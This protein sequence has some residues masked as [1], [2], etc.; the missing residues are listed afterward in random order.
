MVIL[1]VDRAQS[2]G[3]VKKHLQELLAVYGKCSKI[4]MFH[5]LFT[6]K[7]VFIRPGIH[8]MPVRIANREYPDQT[9]SI[10]AV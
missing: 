10:E 3:V 6:N 2:S 5:F 7:I 1:K 8:K 4:S 9:A